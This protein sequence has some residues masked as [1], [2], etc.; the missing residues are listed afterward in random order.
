MSNTYYKKMEAERHNREYEQK[1]RERKWQDE[2]KEN[3][4]KLNRAINKAIEKAWPDK[5]NK[6]KPS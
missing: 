2:E 6:S 3:R 4:E 5:D 1:E